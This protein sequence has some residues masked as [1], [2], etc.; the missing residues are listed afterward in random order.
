MFA[1]DSILYVALT[2]GKVEKITLADWTKSN[3]PFAAFSNVG[4]S[5]FCVKT[6]A[7]ED[8]TGFKSACTGTPQC[9]EFCFD[10][11]GAPT[12]YCGH[13]DAKVEVNT[14]CPGLL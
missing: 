5:D 2:S 12:C 11:A 4:I 8:P 7:T 3:T 9:D 6:A 10:V 1:T 14:D 13:N